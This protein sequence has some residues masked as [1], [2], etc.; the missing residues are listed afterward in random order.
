M[1]VSKQTIAHCRKKLEQLAK[2]GKRMTY[3]ALMQRLHIGR[4]SIKDCLNPIYRDEIDAGRPDLTLIV[5]YAGSRLGRYNSR[6]GPAQSKS[7]KP[8]TPGQVRAYKDDLY[9]VYK[10]WGGKPKGTLKNW[11]G[12]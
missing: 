1:A 6:G 4:N 8:Q 10:Y 11:L 12:C 9:K 2:A 5:H 7:V 3:G